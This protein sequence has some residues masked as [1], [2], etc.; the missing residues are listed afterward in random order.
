[1]DKGKPE[2][3]KMDRPVPGAEGAPPN[4]TAS[5]FAEPVEAGQEASEEGAKPG[6]AVDPK[7]AQRSGG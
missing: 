5:G 3:Y 1:M 6:T 2:P 7:A 4:A